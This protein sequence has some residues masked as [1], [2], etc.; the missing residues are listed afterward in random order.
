MLSLL[1]LCVSVR[2]GAGRAREAVDESM[3]VAREDDTTAGTEVA[4][5]ARARRAVRSAAD[6]GLE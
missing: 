1:A 5:I 4:L 2:V 6:V 3:G